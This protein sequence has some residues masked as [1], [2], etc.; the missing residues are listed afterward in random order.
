MLTVTLTLTLTL[1]FFTLTLSALQFWGL[2]IV[3]FCFSMLALNV[4]FSAMIGALCTLTL[5]LTVT[6]TVSA[7]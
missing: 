4:I 2:Y 6:V 3:A 1:T 5:T 7:P